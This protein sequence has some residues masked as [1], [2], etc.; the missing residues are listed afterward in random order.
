MSRNIHFFAEGLD[1]KVRE[2]G[3]IRAWF[4]QAIK[5][6]GKMEGEIN[7]VFTTDELLR[8]INLKYLNTDTYTDIITFDFSEEEHLVSGDIYISINRVEENSKKY[9]ATFENELHRVLIHGVLHLL[10]F[11]DTTKSEKSKMRKLEN[12]FLD[13]Y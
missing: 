9:K 11:E 13:G 4:N 2:K 8:N 1:F 6:Y 5:E 7:V 3:R 10:G 12:E